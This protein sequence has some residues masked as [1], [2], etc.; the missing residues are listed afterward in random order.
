MIANV[1]HLITL[2]VAAAAVV[3]LV[4]VLAGAARHRPA[5]LAAD[6]VILVVLVLIAINAATGL[7]VFATDKG[8]ADTLHFLYAVLALLVLPV[9]RF[10]DRLSSHRTLALG[11][12]A[13]LLGAFLLRL[14]QTG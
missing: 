9:A 1:H 7:V 10:W 12:G 8:P 11:F 5:R 6:R 3:L 13:V 14:F 2:L 4:I